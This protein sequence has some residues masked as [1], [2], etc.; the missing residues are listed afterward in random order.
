VYFID[1]HPHLPQELDAEMFYPEEPDFLPAEF[2]KIHV[3]ILTRSDRE[4]D[5][6]NRRKQWQFHIMVFKGKGAV[7]SASQTQASRAFISCNYLMYLYCNNELTILQASHFLNARLMCISSQVS[8]QHNYL[9][10]ALGAL[11]LLRSKHRI[12]PDE[13]G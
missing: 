1:G 11:K 8:Q 7:F 2:D 9:L 13:A 12:V 4:L 10:R 5:I 6:S 3:P